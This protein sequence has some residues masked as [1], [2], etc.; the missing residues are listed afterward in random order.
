MTIASRKKK[1]RKAVMQPL[2]RAPSESVL[3][4]MALVVGGSAVDAILDFW[5]KWR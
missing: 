1:E 4:E 2:K 5:Y 3:P